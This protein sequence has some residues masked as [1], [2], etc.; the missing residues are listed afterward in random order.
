MRRATQVLGVA[1][2]AAG[3]L[4]DTSG[5]TEI[6]AP[7]GPPISTSPGVSRRC[8]CDR[9]C[10]AGALVHLTGLGYRLLGRQ[11]EEGMV[12]AGTTVLSGRAVARVTATGLRNRYGAI[13]TLVAQV[14]KERLHLDLETDDVEAP[15][16][17]L[18]G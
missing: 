7:A 6:D 3:L 10:A 18:G 17:R 8:C 13:G 4:L 12:L 16:D 15:H 1:L 9:C 5:E 2:M 14:S 11:R